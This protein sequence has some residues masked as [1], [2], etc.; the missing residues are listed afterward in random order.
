MCIYIYIY[1]YVYTHIHIYAYIY[2]YIYIYMYTHTYMDWVGPIVWPLSAQGG[3]SAS[4]KQ[5]IQPEEPKKL[6][7]PPSSGLPCVEE[8]TDKNTGKRRTA[9]RQESG[10]GDKFLAAGNLRCFPVARKTEA[11]KG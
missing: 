5:G 8:H 1:I 3:N 4:Y 6:S 9:W 2:I 7:P 11:K 10:G